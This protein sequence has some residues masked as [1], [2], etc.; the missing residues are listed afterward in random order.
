MKQ[1]QQAFVKIFENAV[2]AVVGQD[3]IIS[4]KTFNFECDA[5][6]ERGLARLEPR[7]LCLRGNPKP[8]VRD[9]I[10]HSAASF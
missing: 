5:H 10:H 7:F 8:M 3:G 6:H 4:I 1:I 2:Q 9:S